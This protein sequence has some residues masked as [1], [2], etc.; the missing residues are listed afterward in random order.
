MKD[1][2]I[3]LGLC[4]VA[5]AVGAWLF[6]MNPQ[7]LSG[8]MGTDGN[9]VQFTK[10]AAGT[11]ANGVIATTNYLIK[12][13]AELHDLWAMLYGDA[14]PPPLVDFSS[15]EV[16]AVFAGSEP[17][18]G[19]GVSV[20]RISD[21]A[22][23]RVVSVSIEKPGS[24]CAVVQSSTSPYEIVAVPKTALPFTHVDT[25]VSVPCAQ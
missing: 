22:T 15:S 3:I 9:T 24:S 11:N 13:D 17:T 16:I 12:N 7:S 19:F 5:L 21:T 23:A 25:F 6:L 8:I 14:S 20:A 4:L 10:L 2:F 18:T 1:A